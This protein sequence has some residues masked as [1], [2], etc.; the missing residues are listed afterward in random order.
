MIEFEPIT[1]GILHVHV[2]PEA[3]PGFGPLSCAE[4][5]VTSADGEPAPGAAGLI[6]RAGSRV[7][8]RSHPHPSPVQR[9]TTVSSPGDPEEREADE[10][11]DTVMRSAELPPAG[12]APASI[13]RTCAG[14]EDEDKQTLQT[15]RAGSAHAGAVLDT[16]AVVS[17]VQRGGEP[18]PQPTREFF[19]PHFGHDFSR[20][21]VHADRE[22][23]D[24]A[25]AVQEQPQISAR[26]GNAAY[27][28]VPSALPIIA[29]Q[30]TPLLGRLPKHLFL[31]L[32][33]SSRAYPRVTHGARRFSGMDRE[34]PPR[35]TPR[36]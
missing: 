28:M 20:V 22:A 23:A 2:R 31:S 4:A 35:R 21:L 34:C 33:R 16:G 26:A 9:K 8:F 29:C 5:H 13:Q 36:Q 12:S 17:A 30:P 24:A 32:M 6:G 3:A 10:V 7:S 1:S 15:K 27:T 18:L 19:E 11:A 25:H 14:C